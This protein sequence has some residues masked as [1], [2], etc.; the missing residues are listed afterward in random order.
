MAQ[1]VEGSGQLRLAVFIDFE[2]IALGLRDSD[3]TFDVR[4][5]LDR[6]LEKGRVIA[7]VAYADW[8]RFREYTGALHED[9][10][11]RR[12]ART[13]LTSAWWW[14]RWT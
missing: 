1:A 2:N 9:G 8:N 11:E 4:R 5:V 6:L 3:A 12:P 13:R 10:I 14:T 7:K